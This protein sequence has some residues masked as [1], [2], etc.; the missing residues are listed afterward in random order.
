MSTGTWPPAN[1]L[2]EV[3]Y[4]W[5]HAEQA[6]TASIAQWLPQYRAWAC[7]QEADLIA[8][9]VMR[10]RGWEYL[11]PVTNRPHSSYLDT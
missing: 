5:L 1:M 8:P 4:H 7:A 9:H 11:G 3:A 2:D 6:S 10:N